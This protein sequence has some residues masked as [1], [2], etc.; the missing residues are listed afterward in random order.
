MGPDLSLHW[1]LLPR[2]PPGVGA[3]RMLEHGDLLGV[4]W[5]CTAVSH[6]PSA[7]VDTRALTK[8]IREKGTLLG[9]LVPD[10]TLENSLPF[11]DP[12]KRHLVQ[13][14]SLKVWPG[15]SGCLVLSWA[16]GLGGGLGRSSGPHTHLPCRHP[17][18]STRADPC[19][20]PQSTAA[21]STTRS[22]ACAS[23]GRPS[24][25]FPGTIPWTPQ[26]GWARPGAPRAL[27]RGG[28]DLEQ[29]L[30]PGLVLGALGNHILPRDREF[31]RLGII[32]PCGHGGSG[33]G[34][35]PQ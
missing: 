6:G 14:V 9:K 34:G 26:V 4:G 21:S 7:G 35:G 11:E 19:G 3:V 17:A 31:G 24:P 5:G 15:G 25:W 2:A 1:D 12:N 16:A 8:K 20:S 23:G 32:I 18:C 10:E 27:Q 13:E 33:S 29:G 22:G 30:S 28:W